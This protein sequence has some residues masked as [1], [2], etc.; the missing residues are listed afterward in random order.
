MK[1]TIIL[2]VAFAMFQ[3]VTRL[4]AAD[5]NPFSEGMDVCRFVVDFL[6]FLIFYFVVWWVFY[7]LKF[8]NERN[9]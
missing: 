3:I 7:A 9:G 2:V 8:L 1:N 5:Y 4:F 6:F